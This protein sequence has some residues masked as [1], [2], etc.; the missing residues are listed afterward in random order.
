[1]WGRWASNPVAAGAGS[2]S[3]GDVFARCGGDGLGAGGA[4][5]GGLEEADF[6]VVEGV[7]GTVSR[8]GGVGH[9]DI[10]ARGEGELAAL[11]VGC[12]HGGGGGDVGVGEE[13]A[14]EADHPEGEVE[15]CGPGGGEGGVVVG[16]E[17]SDADH[18]GAEVAEEEEVVGE[19]FGGL[20]GE[21]DHGAC[22]GLVAEVAQVVEAG[23]AAV[24][25][26]VGVEAAEE[27]AVGGLDAEEVAFGAGVAEA[28][29]GG[30]G[31]FAD[32]EG[33]GEAGLGSDAFDEAGEAVVGP[34]W[35]FAGLEDDGGDAAACD[36][37]AGVEDLLGAH[38]VASEAGVGA[39][40]AAVGAVLG[41]DVGELDD[42]AD[43]DAVAEGAAAGGVGLA[44]DGGE[45]L[46]GE[47]QEGGQEGDVGVAV[48]DPFEGVGG[49]HGGE[50]SGPFFGGQRGDVLFGGDGRCYIPR[51][52]GARTVLYPGS[53]DPITNG[54]VDVVRRALKI[55]DEVRVAV[56]KDSPKTPLFTVEERVELLRRVF[57]GERRVKV[58]AFSGLLSEYVRACGVTT[59]I[60]GLRMV[61]DFDYE[62]S[63]ALMNRKQH[64]E[65]ETVF[66]MTNEALQ[67]VSSTMVRQIA[68]LGGSVAAFVPPAV[69][70]ALKRKF[71]RGRG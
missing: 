56:A 29:V 31:A 37:A 25:V 33:D 58:E 20:T 34:P 10:G 30:A 39:S 16:E 22:A 13:E 7:V 41:A 70:R 48:A 5:V 69:E 43:E 3:R 28:A 47:S 54:H 53:F 23:E 11:G 60:R 67:F 38:A 68:A 19:A 18:V 45:V 52:M 24:E 44:E 64:P 4:V 9:E 2:R 15:G 14:G 51:T 59:V 49:V 57:A 8:G 63:L 61:T 65:M 17:G 26:V 6:V 36:G 32:G 50:V 66:L 27:V 42:A 40:E 71:R 55:F 35:V 1:M 46:V 21:A 62:F 12:A